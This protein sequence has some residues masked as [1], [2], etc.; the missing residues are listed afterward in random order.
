MKG[1][2]LIIKFNESISS[3]NDDDV[4]NN[5]SKDKYLKNI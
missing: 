3:S 1:K 5:N 4:D 2:K